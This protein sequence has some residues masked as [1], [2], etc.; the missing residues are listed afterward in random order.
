MPH[1]IADVLLSAK[2]CYRVV[3]ANWPNFEAIFTPVLSYLNHHIMTVLCDAKRGQ[4]VFVLSICTAFN[5]IIWFNLSADGNSQA[6]GS[7]CAILFSTI[8]FSSKRVFG[9]HRR[10]NI[11]LLRAALLQVY[12]NSLSARKDNHTLPNFRKHFL[13]GYASF[14]SVTMASYHA[15]VSRLADRL[16]YLYAVGHCAWHIRSFASKAIPLIIRSAFILTIFI[17]ILLIS[18]T[19]SFIF[20]FIH[21]IAIRNQSTILRCT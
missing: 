2:S 11:H 7:V 15:N 3:L 6:T 9:F 17:S 1:Y 19:V 13:L 20:D 10:S 5:D 14:L 21:W 4:A 18:R 8:D 16:I 12:G